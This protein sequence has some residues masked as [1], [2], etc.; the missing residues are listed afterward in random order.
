[1]NPK[2]IGGI[3]YRPDTDIESIVEKLISDARSYTHVQLKSGNSEIIENQ[4]RKE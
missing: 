2:E 4:L 1:L 3:I